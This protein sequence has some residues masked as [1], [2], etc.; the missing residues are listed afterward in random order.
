MLPEGEAGHNE[1][2][3]RA[4]EADGG[5]DSKEAESRTACAAG[6]RWGYF[7]CPTSTE[8][9]HQETVVLVIKKF[10]AIGTR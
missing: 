1:S 8:P 4:C 5:N 2:G 6:G 7:A 3:E 10:I 9:R